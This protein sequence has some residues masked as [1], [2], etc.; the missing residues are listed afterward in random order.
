M[1]TADSMVCRMIQSV[2]IAAMALS[3]AALK[4]QKEL[5][6]N[7]VDKFKGDL[8]KLFELTMANRKIFQGENK[9]ITSILPDGT[10]IKHITLIVNWFDSHRILG[11]INTAVGKYRAASVCK[12]VDKGA[13]VVVW[14]PK[15]LASRSCKSRGPD[16]CC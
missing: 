2:H 10:T 16:T 14:G 5:T 6:A 13:S 15:Q 3:S 9:E 7:I 8:C 12:H 4:R 1:A 11:P